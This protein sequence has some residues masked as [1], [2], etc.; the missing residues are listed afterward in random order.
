MD[1][2]SKEHT[3]VT[4]GVLSDTHGIFPMRCLAELTDCDYLIHAG[5]IGDVGIYRELRNLAP[6]IAVLGNNDY[7]EYGADVKAIAKRTI[8]GVRF[9]VAHRPEQVLLK[10]MRAQYYEPGELL[11]HVCIH[12][13]THVPNIIRGKEASPADLILCPGAVTYPR[14]GSKPSIAKITLSEN[15]VK[16]VWFEEV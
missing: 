1:T 4:I 8:E 2:H 15:I 16:D 6:T 3:D 10:E 13:H 11:P 9:F 5:D 12:G 7:R 14:K